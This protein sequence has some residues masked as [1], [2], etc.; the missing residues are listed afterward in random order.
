MQNKTSQVLIDGVDIRELSIPW[1]RNVIG[2]V[3]QEP[4][5]FADS[6]EANLRL[7]NPSMTSADMERVCR[8][9]HAHEFIMQLPQVTPLFLFSEPFRDDTFSGLLLP[10]RRGRRAALRRPE[11]AHSHCESARERPQSDTRSPSLIVPPTQSGSSPD[12]AS[13]RGDVCS[14]HGERGDRPG[15]ARDGRHT[16]TGSA[17]R[18]KLSRP[19]RVARSSR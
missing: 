16:P 17:N 3:A 11:A 13:R 2:V 1:L 14:G 10:A 12:P 6:I 9:A 4:A 15:G 18:S 5:L 7:G 19:A 8:A